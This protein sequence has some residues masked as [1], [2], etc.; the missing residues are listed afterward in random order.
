[1]GF[2]AF[3]SVFLASLRVYLR[4]D[5][6]WGS[7]DAL[8]VRTMWRALVLHHDVWSWATVWS[9]MTTTTLACLDLK[10]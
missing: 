6:T 9:P 8:A 3:S 4:A 10:F 1:M 2:C 5:R 7:R